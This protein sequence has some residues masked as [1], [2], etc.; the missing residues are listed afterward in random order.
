MAFGLVAVAAVCQS[1]SGKAG[2]ELL[3]A[4]HKALAKCWTAVSAG[5]ANG[6]CPATDSKAMAAIAK[7][8]ISHLTRSRGI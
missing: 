2:S 8:I 5:K 6:T 7:A 1:A 3:N 4:E